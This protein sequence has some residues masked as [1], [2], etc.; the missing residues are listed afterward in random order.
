MGIFRVWGRFVFI[1][2]GWC[3]GR[4]HTTFR[5]FVFLNVWWTCGIVSETIIWLVV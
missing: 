3:C 2:V 1:E 4:C 5:A